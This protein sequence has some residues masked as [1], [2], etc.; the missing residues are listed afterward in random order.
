[1]KKNKKGIS[2]WE[3]VIRAFALLLPV[4]FSSCSIS[5]QI[6]KQANTILIKRYRH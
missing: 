6:S 1:M 4:I 2:N 3:L 5:K